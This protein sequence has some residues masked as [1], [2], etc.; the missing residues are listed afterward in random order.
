MRF[1]CRVCRE[2]CRGEISHHHIKKYAVFGDGETIEVCRTPCHDAL[3]E[4]IRIK[5]NE[6]L[7]SHPEIYYDALKEISFSQENIDYYYGL[8]EK[9][10]KKTRNKGWRY[11]K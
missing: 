4:L 6:L 1:F 7:R 10:R 11:K 8:I 9:R 2:W 5:E 3:E